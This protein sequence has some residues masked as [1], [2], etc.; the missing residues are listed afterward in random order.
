VRSVRLLGLRAALPLL[1]EG[2]HLDPQAA[3][4]AGIVDELASSR[5]DVMERALAWVRSD[6]DPTQPWDRPDYTIPGLAP[7]AR[8][9]AELS[10]APAMLTSRTHGAYPAPERILAAAVEGLFVDVD[11]AFEIET[12]YFLELV[13]S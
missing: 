8:G 6:P 5:E 13:T 2:T 4:R 12:R 10:V 11:T 3:L 7:G 9:Y 1:V